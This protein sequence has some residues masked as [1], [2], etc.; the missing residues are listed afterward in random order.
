[1][2]RIAVFD[3]IQEYLSVLQCSC[4]SHLLFQPVLVIAVQQMFSLI[5]CVCFIFR[6][7]PKYCYTELH[8]QQGDKDKNKHQFISLG[9]FILY[10]T[11]VALR[12]MKP[13][14]QMG[15]EIKWP[16]R[17]SDQM[18]SFSTDDSMHGTSLPL[19][20]VLT[21]LYRSRRTIRS[22]LCDAISCIRFIH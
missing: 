17:E 9:F 19:A 10:T 3:Y 2:D 6:W 13:T 16:V 4:L 21:P 15:P 5:L 1:M 12:S 22:H 11:R 7:H 20:E 14:I 18:L 8:R